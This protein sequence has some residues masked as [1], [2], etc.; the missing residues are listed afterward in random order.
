MCRCATERAAFVCDAVCGAFHS[1]W[2]YPSSCALA[3]RVDMACC[4]FPDTGSIRRALRALAVLRIFVALFNTHEDVPVTLLDAATRVL[5]YM[6]RVDP[7]RIRR[8]VERYVMH[9]LASAQ[10]PS[11]VRLEH[12][13]LCSLNHSG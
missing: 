13:Y 6:R 8:A 12:R 5:G 7:Q 4:V 3:A 9:T 10:W 1:R 2:A 11:V